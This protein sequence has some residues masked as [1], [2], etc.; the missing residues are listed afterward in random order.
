MISDISSVHDPVT[1]GNLE[2]FLHYHMNVP[3]PDWFA[4]FEGIGCQVCVEDKWLNILDTP[5]IAQWV[6]HGFT[7]VPY[8]SD[9]IAYTQV[10]TPLTISSKFSGCAMALFRF[11]PESEEQYVC[12]ISTG[13]KEAGLEDEFARYVDKKK[14]TGYF[15]PAKICSIL[16]KN[17]MGRV[18][19]YSAD[20]TSGVFGIITDDGTCYSVVIRRNNV[21]ARFIFAWAKWTNKTTFNIHIVEEDGGCCGCC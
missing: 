6:Q 17:Y 1:P 8:I 12:H 11:N 5:E 3:L 19:K 2:D 21:N 9:K 15:K 18:T 20:L 4:P 10:R 16:S 13:G 14:I 7:P